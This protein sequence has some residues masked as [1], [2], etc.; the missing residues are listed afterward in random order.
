M[1][2]VPRKLP[3]LDQ[4]YTSFLLILTS[5]SRNLWSERG[6][7]ESLVPDH[8]SPR[9]VEDSSHTALIG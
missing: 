2:V 5:G 7:R 3:M 4:I 6:R 1:G 9:L 8:A